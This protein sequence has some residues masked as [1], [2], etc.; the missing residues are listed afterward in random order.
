MLGVDVSLPTRLPQIRAGVA[1]ARAMLRGASAELRQSH[2]DLHASFVA[3][4]YMLRFS[5]REV[6][7]LLGEVEPTTERLAES[8]AQ[9]YATGTASFVEL[10][11]AQRARLEVREALAEARIERERRVAELEQLAGLDIEMLATQPNDKR[12]ESKDEHHE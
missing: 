10:L 6:D 12:N 11:D 3:A 7:F 4:L 2:L 1:E 8:T 5:E 9:S